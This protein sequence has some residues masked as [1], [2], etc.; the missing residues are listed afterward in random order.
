MSSKAKE[1]HLD[2]MDL[3]RNG[4]KKAVVRKLEF[5]EET[6]LEFGDKIKLEFE[7][8]GGAEVGAKLVRNSNERDVQ[9]A[10]TDASSTD[11]RV[12]NM[13][14]IWAEV[15]VPEKY[16]NVG[17]KESLTASQLS[18]VVVSRGCT[19]PTPTAAIYRRSSSLL[20]YSGELMNAG[21]DNSS[22]SASSYA[23]VGLTNVAPR[24][25]NSSSSPYKRDTVISRFQPPDY[26]FR[27][28]EVPNTWQT[29]VTKRRDELVELGQSPW[30]RNAGLKPRTRRRGSQRSAVPPPPSQVVQA[31]TV[32]YPRT[33]HLRQPVLV[34]TAP[35]L[36]QLW[37]KKVHNFWNCATV[38]VCLSLHF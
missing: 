20:S 34:P 17:Q 25:E 14:S 7:D 38:A 35:D 8:V 11:E 33:Y 32:V 5:K 19:N 21:P 4:H 18:E 1:E 26:S 10:L 24:V 12:S 16:A 2:S 28:E 13:P 27:T 30:N 6:K 23:D 15:V 9:L 29:S 36:K 22:Y 3:L 37:I 31:T